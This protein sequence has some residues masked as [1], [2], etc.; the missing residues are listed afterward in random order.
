MFSLPKESS[1]SYVGDY[2][3]IS[4]TYVLS[5]VFE[6]IGSGKLSRFWK[7]TVCFILSFSIV[8]ALEH[9]MFC[10]HCLTTCRLLCIEGRLVQLNFSAAFGKVSYSGVLYKLRSIAIGRQVLPIVSQ[11]LNNK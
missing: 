4:I 8:G 3:P 7:V 2:R 10:S 6:K 9:V 1:S 11:Y 5:K